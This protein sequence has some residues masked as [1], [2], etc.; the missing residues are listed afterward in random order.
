MKW[1]KRIIHGGILAVIFIIALV[2]FSLITNQGDDSMT[3]DMGSATF[4]QVSF[5]YDGYNVNTLSGYS[6]E[7][8]IPAIRDTIT[9]VNNGTLGMDIHAFDNT[10]T[11]VK[12]KVYTLD[13]QEVLQEGEEKKPAESVSLQLDMASL[14]DREAVLEVSLIT[15]QDKE[16]YYYTR[17]TDASGK[18]ILENLDYV[19]AFHENAMGKVENVGVGTA[20]EP[21]DEG[22]NTTFQHVTI[23]SDY[24]HVSWGQLEPEV[25]KGERWSIKE[26]NNVSTSVELQYLV[27][28][29]GEENETDLYRVT[30]Y[31]RVRYISGSGK[32]YLLDY[33]RTMDQIFDPSKTVLNE[34]GVLLGIADTDTPY[35]V[36]GDGTVV[37]FVAADE[38]WNYNKESDE[39]SQIFSFMDV[40]NTD[41]RNLVTQYE[42]ELLNMD[43]AGNLTFAVYG[44]MNRGEHEGEVGAAIY[45][46]NIATSSTEEKVFIPSDQSYGN[47]IQDLGRYLYYSVDRDVMYLMLDGTL[48]EY[49][50]EED[51]KE[52]I[53]EGLGEGQYSISEDG[54]LICYQVNGGEDSATVLKVLNLESGK[55]R[56]ISC[57]EDESIKPLGFIRTDVVYGVAKSADIGKTV[58]GESIVPMYKVEIQN[59]KG[60]I[61][62]TYQVDGI[63]VMDAEFED[64]MITLSRVTKNGEV[65]NSVTPDS[66]TNNEEKEESN[67]YLE[68]Y[69]TELKETQV[70]LTY[71]DG[72]TDK[73]P[74]VLRPKQ[75]LYENPKT[76]TFEDAGTTE[77][78]AVYGYGKLRGSYEKAGAAIQKANEYN[79]VV[80]DSRQQ[81]VWERGNRDLHYQIDGK[82]D[83]IQSIRDQLSQGVTPADI[84]GKVNNGK[85]LDLTGCT[86]EELLYLINQDRPIIAMLNTTESVIL[87]GYNEKNVIYIDTASGSQAS[88]PY[89]QMDQMTEGSGNT[90]IG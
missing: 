18:N 8:D 83:V 22:D 66:I 2:V 80:V 74:K 48:Y 47:V 40:E 9:P 88:V 4:P 7:M 16:I 19:Q 34:K 37:A 38:L 52:V 77:K 25:E 3:A 33:D 87:V 76:V 53:V 90:Y 78:Y 21:S 75:V 60:E 69:V 23:H 58:S 64:N 72:I 57:A 45:Y 39:T 35:L 79:G 61:K 59:N 62:K 27:R 31:F 85:Y 15:D 5:S 11:K 1:K 42:I 26:T 24:D 54:R 36:N 50:M 29:K 51:K 6:R 12:W 13:G 73:S 43:D 81:Y 70:R 89:E 32:N 10:I 14:P 71:D 49:Q 44:Y 63:Y 68:T 86:T 65:Y 20:I 67:I 41:E 17:I 82:D 46:Y 55:S 30:E 56:E 28:C 84:M